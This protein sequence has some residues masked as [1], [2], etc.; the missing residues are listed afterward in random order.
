M[1]V[2][3]ERGKAAI[4]IFQ[5]LLPIADEF[6]LAKKNVKLETEGEQAIAK[7]FE[8]LFEKLMATWREAGVEKLEALGEEFNPELHEAVSMLPSGDYKEDI[9]CGEL[10]GGWVLK[11][12]GAE[13]IVIRRARLCELGPRSSVDQ[14]MP[15]L[16]S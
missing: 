9:V 3:S 11:P 7:K 10:R 6:E 1:G 2:S 4:P 8:T 16:W 14:S 12:L 15:Q 13:P 5:K